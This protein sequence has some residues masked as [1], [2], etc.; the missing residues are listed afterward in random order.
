MDITKIH[1]M[2]DVLALAGMFYYNNHRF[3]IMENTLKTQAKEIDILKKEMAKLNKVIYAYNMNVGNIAK[4]DD[5]TSTKQQSVNNK[6]STNTAPAPAPANLFTSQSSANY[7]GGVNTLATHADKPSTIY[8]KS[9]QNQEVNSDSEDLY[10][11]DSGDSNDYDDSNLDNSDQ[12]DENDD[13]N[14]S[15]QSDRIVESDTDN[16]TKLN[17]SDDDSDDIHFTTDEDKDQPNE[18]VVEYDEDDDESY[19][20]DEDDAGGVDDGNVEKSTELPKMETI[21][22]AAKETSYQMDKLQNT[23]STLAADVKITK[24]IV[25]Y[26]IAELE[27]MSKN[28]LIKMCKEVGIAP[29]NKNKSQMS[30]ALHKYYKNKV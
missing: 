7:V 23:I 21:A 13:V 4:L 26:E 27:E 10:T 18:V 15:D 30:E 9:E 20:I 28:D 3:S 2:A 6:L 14:S 22:E 11:D 25:E 17:L 8:K 24:K 16:K 19:E 12:D 5:N 29:S 1:M